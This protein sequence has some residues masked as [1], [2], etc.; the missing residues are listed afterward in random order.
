M[1]LTCKCFN[2]M[3]PAIVTRHRTIKAFRLFCILMSYFSASGVLFSCRCKWCNIGTSFCSNK[4]FRRRRTALFRWVAKLPA[5]STSLIGSLHVPCWKII[6]KF[7]LYY[8]VHVY[9][10]YIFLHVLSTNLYC[11]MYMYNR[12]KFSEFLHCLLM[13]K[14]SRII[15]TNVFFD[16]SIAH[17][18]EVGWLS[19]TKQALCWHVAKWLPLRI[20]Q[21]EISCI[22]QIL[23][24]IKSQISIFFSI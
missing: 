10:L 21:Q 11:S 5:L 2:E 9:T 3:F 4:I 16:L 17:L 6:L 15:E 13:Q 19:L 22:L 23:W 7:T 24:C 12:P 20:S 18:E 14:L 8:F 1:K